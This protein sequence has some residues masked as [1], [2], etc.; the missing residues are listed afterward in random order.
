VKRLKSSLL[1]LLATLAC[2]L[3]EPLAAH[4]ALLLVARDGRYAITTADA[5][6]LHEVASA[7]SRSTYG[8]S[9]GRLAI[10]SRRDADA[11]DLQIFDRRTFRLI[12][13]WS[14]PGL[15]AAQLSGGSGDIVLSNQCA[16]F[17]TVR[18][19]PEGPRSGPGITPFDFHKVVL[20]DGALTTI[21]LPG[22]CANPRL[23]DVQGVPFLHS[24][25]GED[26]W[27]YDIA[28]GTFVRVVSNDDLDESFTTD[29]PAIP[30]PDLPQFADYRVLPDGSVF[31]LSREGTVK[32]ILQ[33]DQNPPPKNRRSVQVRPEGQVIRVYASEL[34]KRPVVGVLQQLPGEMAFSLSDATTK[35]VQWTA[36]LPQSV[37]PDSLV[38][39]SDGSIFYVDTEAVAIFRA[40]AGGAK[41]VW[42]LAAEGSIVDPHA[43]RIIAV[44]PNPSA[45]AE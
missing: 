44:T 11:S 3:C 25:N 5:A 9:P 36:K 34:G 1:V 43:T 13:S 8:L 10:L 15:P 18:Y 19:T 35:A 26:V 28:S 30:Q 32:E 12:S 23:T 7:K 37:A 22:D 42:K 17:V 24:W 20:A 38:I 29:A 31:R 14:V 45:A 2:V 6:G 27:R 39:A 41:R 4:Q 33:A 21:P 16:Y 40:S